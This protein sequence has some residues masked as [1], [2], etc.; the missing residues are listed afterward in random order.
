VTFETASTSYL[1]IKTLEVDVFNQDI[2]F[3]FRTHAA[4]GILLYAHDNLHNFVQLHLEEPG[5]I[6]FTFNNGDKI[7]TVSVSYN[8]FNDGKWHQIHVERS[9]VNTTL[10]VDYRHSETIEHPEGLV[11]LSSYNGRPFGISSRE[12]I[13]PARPGYAIM[14]FKNMYVGGVATPQIRS[15]IPGFYGC[16]RGLKI[17]SKLYQLMREPDTDITPG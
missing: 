13:V 10:T 3:S 16:L 6:I 4:A 1:L 2:L 14:P 7:K 17:G 9:A 12:K 5:D 8:N 15:T 11:P